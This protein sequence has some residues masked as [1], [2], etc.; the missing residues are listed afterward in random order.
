VGLTLAVTVTATNSAGS[1][2]QTSQPTAAVTAVPTVATPTVSGTVALGQTLTA[3]PGTTT[4]TP[5]P[6][7]T[8]Q[9]QRCNQSGQSCSAISGATGTTYTI[10]AA[11]AG[12]TLVFQVTATNSAGTAQAGSQPTTVVSGA[13]VNTSH[14]PSRAASRWAGP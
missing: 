3:T 13:P 4:G 9:W 2:S 1:A 14:R 7:V 8:Y 11:D 12:S 10:A 6:T 5:T